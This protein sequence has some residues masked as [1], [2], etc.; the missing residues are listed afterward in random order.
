MA[1]KSGGRSQNASRKLARGNPKTRALDAYAI[2]EAEAP[3]KIKIAKHRLGEAPQDEGRKRR[4]GE[5]EDERDGS[6]DEDM[7]SDGEVRWKVGEVDEDEDSELDSDEAMGESDEERFAGFTFRGSSSGKR[8]KKNKSENKMLDLS[9]GESESEE[10]ETDLEGE[11]WMD[12]SE[13]LDTPE[14]RAAKAK[15]K[16]KADAISEEEQY[17]SSESEES[18]DS[19]DEEEEDESGDSDFP[20]DEEEEEADDERLAALHSAI[21]SLPSD[22]TGRKT[23]RQRLDDPNEGKMPSEYNLSTTEKLTLDDLMGTVTDPKLRKSLKLLESEKGKLSAPLPKRQQDRLDRAAAYEKSTKELDKW[24]A[25]VK[26]NREADHLIFPLPGTEVPAPVKLAANT[27]SAPLTSL[28]EKIS[29]ILQAS[30]MTSEKKIQEFETLKTNKMSIEEVQART[31]QLRLAREL[32]YREEAKAKRLKK[33]KSKSYHRIKKRERKK[34][35]QAME[36]AMA[37]EGEGPNDEEDAE[38]RDRRRAEERMSLRYKSSKWAKGVKESGK[39]MWDDEARDGAIEMIR[40]E[41]EL[42]RRIQGKTIRT[43]DGLDGD[44]S[45]SSEDDDSEDENG[46]DASKLKEKL[47]KNLDGLEMSKNTSD[48]GLGSK[49][50]NLKFMKQAEAARAQ[51]NKEQIEM[52]RRDLEADDAR[53]SGSDYDS[54]ENASVQGRRNFAP[55]PPIEEKAKKKNIHGEDGPE[56]DDDSGDG[57]SEGEEEEVNFIVNA[58]EN[59]FSLKGKSRRGQDANGTQTKEDTNGI[60]SSNPWLS[61]NSSGTKSTKGLSTS[62]SDTKASKASAKLSKAKRAVHEDEDDQDVQID[63]NLTLNTQ[64]TQK[65]KP[66]TNGDAADD[67]DDDVDAAEVNLI[68]AKKSGRVSIQAQQRSLVKQAFAGD[69]VVRDFEEEKRAIVEEEGDKVIDEG[70]PG[71]VCR[72][73]PFFACNVY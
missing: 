57:K 58:P 63:V 6:D 16:R 35:E 53:G 70:L 32:L 21:I 56:T 8:G 1:G 38:E 33:I 66:S 39:A 60:T 20:M 36:E 64:T 31:A 10:D 22:A 50:L 19:D 14:E 44:T 59:P 40:R 52:L 15:L 37:L 41:E 5:D 68:A 12:L 9:E 28:E 17:G 34:Q 54:D 43:E 4:T 47:L 30:N 61:A 69:D 48:N 71:W 23:K 42:R 13:M 62:K 18:G 72:S 51:Q 67:E 45:S 73:K 24:E 65:T 11:G 46:D 55:K 29:E 2:A 49:L 7:E 25:T 3:E 26:H 27:V